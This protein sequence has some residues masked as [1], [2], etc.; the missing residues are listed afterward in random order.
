MVLFVLPS[1]LL[2]VVIV[3]MVVIVVVISVVVVVAIVGVVVVVVG[4]SVSF[5]NKLSL[6]IG[7]GGTGMGHSTRVSVSL[8]EISFEGNK[9]WELNIGDS[10]NTGDGGKIACREIT[11][12]GGGIVSY[13]C[14]TSIFKSSCK[15]KK[16][17]MSN[18]YLVKSFEESGEMLPSEAAK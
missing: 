8:G 15:G 4:S 11:T 7:D 13:A 5:I 14:M 18:R 16:T 9:S 17:S 1:I 3:V 10:D 2:V 6:V 12:W